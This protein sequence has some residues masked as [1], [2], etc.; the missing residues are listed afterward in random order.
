M[1]EPL[2]LKEVV[3]PQQHHDTVCVMSDDHTPSE[4]E[5]LTDDEHWD[6]IIRCTEAFHLGT[7]EPVP[8]RRPPADQ[9]EQR[10]AG[11]GGDW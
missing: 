10:P 11:Y 5:S 4:L 9:A 7:S 3:V 6:L 8:L 2:T 1:S